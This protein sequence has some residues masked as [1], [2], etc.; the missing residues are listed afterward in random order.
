MELRAKVQ[1]TDNTNE[2]VNVLTSEGTLDNLFHLSVYR[3]NVY[4]PSLLPH[5]SIQRENWFKLI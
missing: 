1:L 5:I 4:A 2:Q 3:K